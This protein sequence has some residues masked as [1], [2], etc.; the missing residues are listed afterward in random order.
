[1]KSIEFFSV[2]LT[3]ADGLVRYERAGGLWDGK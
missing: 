3:P 1:M 2:S